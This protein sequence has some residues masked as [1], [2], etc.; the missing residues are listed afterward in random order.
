M[1]SVREDLTRFERSLIYLPSMSI[2]FLALQNLSKSFSKTAVLK[3]LHL[4]INQGEFTTLLGP[5]GCGKTTTLRL[6]AGLEALDEG[7]IFLGAKEIQNLPAEKRPVNTVFQH[8]ALFPHLSVKEN[9]AFGLRLKG[10]SENST[11][12]KVMEMLSLVGMESLNSRMPSQLSGGQQQRV[13]LA[14]ALVMEPQVLL[15]DEPMA[16][17][18]VQLRRQM[19]NELKS[20]QRRLGLTCILVTHDQEEAMRLS[21]RIAIMHHGRLLQ[22]GNARNLYEEPAN[23]FCANFMGRANLLP[24]KVLE[25][26]THP[27]LLLDGHK[28]RAPKMRAV[29]EGELVTLFLRPEHVR[30]LSP[31]LRSCD[32]EI[33]ASVK[34]VS[35]QGESLRIYVTVNAEVEIEV[36]LSGSDTIRNF[37]PGD[38]VRLGWNVEQS[39]ILF[40]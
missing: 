29:S 7:K 4:E 32:N 1:R 16:A 14:R 20:I 5:S 10:I 26:E 15:L 11:E 33:D 17:L 6:I 27:S 34:Q 2:S 18:D 12:K 13:A 31:G 25:A 37:N 39:R 9:V 21:D 36:S 30:I 35:F 38:E 8:Y 40:D 3:N 23:R 19:Q 28:I 22:I 24:V